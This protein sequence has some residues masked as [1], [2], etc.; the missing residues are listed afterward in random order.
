MR[1]GSPMKM[2]RLAKI[3]MAASTVGCVLAGT[4]GCDDARSADHRARTAIEES[5]R[6]RAKGP[7]GLD[8]AQ[9]LLAKA[10]QE[11]DA[12]NAT[13]AHAKA[14]LAHTEMDAAAAKIS[15]PTGGINQTNAQSYLA[16]PNVFAVGGSWVIPRSG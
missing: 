15:D 4:I 11:N 3:A 1:K 7:D 5:R 2:S 16:L 10:A 14:M 12:S 13:K 6:A 9:Q 8:E